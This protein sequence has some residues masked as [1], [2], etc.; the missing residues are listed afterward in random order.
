MELRGT[1]L[2][3]GI[4]PRVSTTR[5]PA[6]LFAELAYRRKVGFVLGL[7]ARLIPALTC[8]SA[9]AR[10][11]VEFLILARP[12]Q[13]LQNYQVRNDWPNNNRLLLK[14]LTGT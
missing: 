5:A 13:H 3:Q 6:R 1:A 12:E 9:H 7:P 4:A 14:A 8:L 2:F 10:W 11:I